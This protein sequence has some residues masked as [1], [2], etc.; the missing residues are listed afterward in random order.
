MF[1]PLTITPLP[2]G[3][4]IILFQGVVDCGGL[5]RAYINHTVC[6]TPWWQS[7]QQAPPTKLCGPE[8]EPCWWQNTGILG[9]FPTQR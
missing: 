1:W 5:K 6:V 9:F 2:P 4:K 7:G 3:S 8:F